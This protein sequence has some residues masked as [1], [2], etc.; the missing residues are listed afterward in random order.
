MKLALIQAACA[1]GAFVLLAIVLAR[2]ERRRE[3]RRM[4]QMRKI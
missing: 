2:V 3:V 1:A 4:H